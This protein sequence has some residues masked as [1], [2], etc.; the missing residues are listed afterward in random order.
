M[1]IL[2]TEKEKLQT[3]REEIKAI[4][5]ECQTDSKAECDVCLRSSTCRAKLDF[6]R[7][8]LTLKE[9][10]EYS[11]SSSTHFCERAVRN[12][13]KL[14]AD[15]CKSLC[16][17]ITNTSH[18]CKTLGESQRRIEEMKKT[19]RW[20]RQVKAIFSGGLCQVHSITFETKLTPHY[21]GDIYMNAKLDITILGQRRQ[22]DGVKLK[23]GH[24]ARLAADVA[25]NAVEWYRK[26][27][28]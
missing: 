8:K 23:F 18:S 10:L 7:R 22:I 14:K 3:I 20:V 11:R 9:R 17:N 28:T 21:I 5:T 12:N 26:T 27:N 24:F 16:K 15:E 2:N 4:R 13:C 25:S 1:R 6:C 19:S